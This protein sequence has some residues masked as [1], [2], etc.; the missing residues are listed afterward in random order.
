MSRKNI[1]IITFGTHST[2]RCLAKQ[3]AH[4]PFKSLQINTSRSFSPLLPFLTQPCIYREGVF[5][6][7]VSRC[8]CQHRQLHRTETTAKSIVM[9]HV[10]A[11]LGAI[12]ISS[13]LTQAG[14]LNGSGLYDLCV[15]DKPNGRGTLP[16][17]LNSQIRALR[18]IAWGGLN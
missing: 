18:M 10:Y 14:D 7:L 15:Y 4:H 5:F 17:Y 11:I 8:N 1:E 13:G 3:G 6:A 12:M 16:P 9:R 2:A